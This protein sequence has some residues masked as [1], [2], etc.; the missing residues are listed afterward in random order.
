MEDK[1]KSLDNK[2]KNATLY[3]EKIEE[4]KKS[5]F[6]FWKFA[7][8]DEAPGLNPGTEEKEKKQEKPKLKKTFNY[9]E[10]F[11]D[12]GIEADKLQRDK[13]TRKECDS[14]YIASTEIIDD[15][16][17]IKEEKEINS[18]VFGKLKKEA[19]QEIVLFNSENF[20]IF[21][22]V[23]EDKT[24]I[25]I[26][27]NKKHREVK[28]DKFKI[29]DISK[30]MQL[31]EYEDKIKECYESLEKAL[32]KIKAITDIN[33]YMT[34]EEKLNTKHVAQ[35]HINPINAIEE[36]DKQNEKIN[37]YK[38]SIKEGMNIIY[39][40]NIMYYD[41][42]NNTLPKGMNISDNVLIDMSMYKIKLKKQKVFRINKDINDIETKTKIV[43]VYEYE[44]QET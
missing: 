2:I 22:N 42:V 13:L 26:L 23:K 4:H 14:V 44:I 32:K 28:K 27:A 24:K 1:I 10:D 12:L 5:I 18:E 15:L 11:E 36:T 7:N 30:N 38:L 17:K 33:L 16:N 41:N 19:E 25:S 20:D 8:K 21:G 3:I 37:L 34:S 39:N 43:C 31:E 40:T 29:L 6:E 9:E 35:F